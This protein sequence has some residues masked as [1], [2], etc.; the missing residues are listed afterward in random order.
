[1]IVDKVNELTNNLYEGF[2]IKKAGYNIAKNL[3][4][5]SL[6]FPE[7][8][9]KTLLAEDKSIL[10]NAFKSIVGNDII[11]KLHYDYSFSD[12]Y[13]VKNTVCKYLAKAEPLYCNNIDVD[14]IEVIAK[15]TDFYVTFKLDGG[16]YNYL[17]GNGFKCG[18]TKYLSR[19]FTQNAEI[20]F[21]QDNSKDVKLETLHLSNNVYA[22]ASG[23]RTVAIS[24]TSK[25]IGRA[26]M[27][28]PSYIVDLKDNPKEMIVACGKVSNIYTKFLEASGKTLL[29]FTLND[30]TGSI[31]AVKF[32]KSKNSEYKNLQE[33][34][35]VVVQG[36]VSVNTYDDKLQIIANNVSECKIDYTSINTE[37]IYN[38]A[39]LYYLNAFPEPYAELSQT[40]IF[41]RTE[42][43]SISLIG[44]T[45]VAFDLETTGLSASDRIIEIGAVKMVDG[46][47]T[48]MFNA[49]VNPEIHI[50][51]KASKVNNIYDKDVADAKTI[52]E[53]F[54][55]FYKFIG[56]YPLIAHNI[57]FDIGFVNTVAKRMNYKIAN[58]LIDT[59][60]LSRKLLK[61]S[62]YNLGTVCGYF[63]IDIGTA[64]R[65]C[66]DA[67]ACC[68]VF[69]KL[70]RIAE[71]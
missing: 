43:P 57:E 45:Y 55:D 41:E 33:G 70:V 34:M 36:K 49:M 42:E 13:L 61:L 21:V 30:T 62:K 47:F 32:D 54:P 25:L 59:Y 2:I 1:M 3:L 17:S 23:L 69:K 19:H 38:S 48:E 44:K 52:E 46:E 26:F 16:S 51:E 64:H 6:V 53:I 35:E 14:D 5:I 65:A 50:P 68:K 7:K 71:K 39:N 66:Y 12:G 28:V 56:E 18:L 58:E 60:K 29:K 11:V 67:V 63:D 9:Y 27:G 20:N 40:N 10:L 31:N 15:E 4:D 24:D 8:Y 37:P 22:S